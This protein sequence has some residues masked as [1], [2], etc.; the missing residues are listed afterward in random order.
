MKKPLIDIQALSFSYENERILKDL[1]F[2]IAD[3]DFFIIIG[4]NGSGKSTLLKIISG[5]IAPESGRV[6][7]KGLPIKQY[8]RKALARM[9]ALVPQIASVDFP[10]TVLDVVLMGRA[11]HLGLLGLEQ[12]RDIQI[13]MQSLEFTGVSRLAHRKMDQLSGGEQQRVFIAR[14]I[15]QDPEIILLDEPTASLDL[16]HQ[17]RVMDLMEQL[18]C[19]KGIT[20]VMVSHDVNLAAMYGDCL[21][22]LKDGEIVEAG[23]PKDVINFKTLE[24]TYECTLLVDESPLGNYPRITQVPKKYLVSG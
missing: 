14:A 1:S 5:I 23:M 6:T 24:E 19:E 10:F 17:I 18:K 8:A 22:L 2:T 16:A 15:C 12:K 7:I 20:I 13:A 3:N 11:P 4:P 9:I 21:L